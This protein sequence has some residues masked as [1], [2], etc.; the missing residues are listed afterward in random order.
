MPAEK[1]MTA[2][3]RARITLRNPAGIK[4]VIVEVE[5]RVNSPIEARGVP[6]PIRPKSKVT[7]P[8]EVAVIE[9]VLF[10]SS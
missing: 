5:K 7:K 8:V 10:N 4:L 9:E 3:A 1:Y 6:V 2:T